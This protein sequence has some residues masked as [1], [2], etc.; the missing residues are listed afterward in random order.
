MLWRTRAL[1]E[2]AQKQADAVR[3]TTARLATELVILATDAYAA[4]PD[5]VVVCASDKAREAD[6]D[7]R[8]AERIANN[9]SRLVAPL[10]ELRRTGEELNHTYKVLKD[11]SAALKT[12]AFPKWL[13]LRRPSPAHP[14]LPAA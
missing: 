13:T 14:R 2:E 11:L 5:Q 10:T 4:D 6:A 1:A 3:D 8:T 12:G 9:F 7:A